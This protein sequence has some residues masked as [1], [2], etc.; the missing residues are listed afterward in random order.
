ML[1]FVARIS[2]MPNVTVEIF[3]RDVDVVWQLGVF[4]V[5]VNQ[6]VKSDVGHRS[7]ASRHTHTYPGNAS[8]G[9]RVIVTVPANFCQTHTYRAALV[10]HWLM[11]QHHN[12]CKGEKTI[13]SEINLKAATA[14]EIC[15]KSINTY[16]IASE[17]FVNLVVCV[18]DKFS[19]AEKQIRHTDWSQICLQ[20]LDQIYKTTGETV[21]NYNQTNMWDRDCVLQVDGAVG[22]MKTR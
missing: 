20:T 3:S 8:V 21:L 12:L 17:S 1:I 6:A 13:K 9:H 10:S 4:R 5:S 22:V 14:V 15:I 16:L 11:V 19:Q 7:R 18:V 2:L